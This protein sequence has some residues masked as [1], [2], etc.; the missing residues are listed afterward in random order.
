MS[1][2]RISIVIACFLCSFSLNGQKSNSLND[3]LSKIEYLFRSGEL[4]LAD[5]LASRIL[6]NES[7]DA[8]V[9]QFYKLLCLAYKVKRGFEES[10]G[11]PIVY[12]F[13]N[14]ELDNY[15]KEKSLIITYFKIR[16]LREYYLDCLNDTDPWIKNRDDAF[17][18]RVL[19]LIEQISE[20]AIKK[21]DYG[22]YPL[23][24]YSAVF[25]SKEETFNLNLFIA[26]KVCEE[27]TSFYLAALRVELPGQSLELTNIDHAFRF[28]PSR[29][30][31]NLFEFRLIEGLN[32]VMTQRKRILSNTGRG[33]LFPYYELKIGLSLASNVNFKGLDAFL[34][35]ILSDVDQKLADF[36]TLEYLSW[37]TGMGKSSKSFTPGKILQ[38]CNRAIVNYPRTHLIHNNS[39][40]LKYQLEEKNLVIKGSA[41]LYPYQDQGLEVQSRNIDTLHYILCKNPFGYNNEFRNLVQRKQKD[42]LKQLIEAN[43]ILKDQVAIGPIEVGIE[44]KFV[45]EILGQS[46]GAYCLFV[47]THEDILEGEYTLYEYNVARSATLEYIDDKGQVIEYEYH[48]NDFSFI[49]ESSINYVAPELNKTDTIALFEK[50]A[51]MVNK[52]DTVQLN[53]YFLSFSDQL[54]LELMTNHPSSSF[55]NKAITINTQGATDKMGQLEI[56]LH[57]DSG[58]FYPLEFNLSDSSQYA[59]STVFNKWIDD[60]LPKE[61][62]D[63]SYKQNS[64]GITLNAYLFGSSDTLSCTIEFDKAIPDQIMLFLDGKMLKVLSPTD[65]KEWSLPVAGKVEYGMHMLELFY[66]SESTPKYYY[67]PFFVQNEQE[68]MTL[69]YSEEKASKLGASLSGTLSKVKNSFILISGK[70]KSGGSDM[71][72]SGPL[73]SSKGMGVSFQATYES[74]FNRSFGLQF[75]GIDPSKYLRKQFPVVNKFKEYDSGVFDY[76]IN[77]KGRFVGAMIES[78]TDLYELDSANEFVEWGCDILK[79]SPFDKNDTLKKGVFAVVYVDHVGNFV[80][81]TPWNITGDWE[82]NILYIGEQGALKGEKYHLGLKN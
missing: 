39:L 42:A 69:E 59:N 52:L 3:E 23:R 73:F 60:Q 22:R 10:T 62:V 48:T 24:D 34:E 18:G 17:K 21:R 11:T 79:I 41:V 28:T 58:R 2:I 9:E 66:I 68:G 76:K 67:A 27:I 75:A 37:I 25:S 82:F 45:L 72:C 40:I 29:S 26:D 16:S 78:N 12:N 50:P 47:G 30:N 13:L 80:L 77:S 55:I 44:R 53:A 14:E 20:K 8:D 61:F 49:S 63:S 1:V 31:T 64:V 46:S 7:K 74:L 5:E 71:N 57:S 38:W 33:E 6:L 19:S 35:V 15:R 4:K 36:L 51:V 81:N 70:P 54:G 56:L 32:T 65:L 43:Q